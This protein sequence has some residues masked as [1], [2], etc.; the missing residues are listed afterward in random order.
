MWFHACAILRV[1][2]QCRYNNSSERCHSTESGQSWLF[3]PCTINRIRDLLPSQFPLHLSFLK[4]CSVRAIISIILRCCKPP[5][6]F[7]VLDGQEKQWL[8]KRS[9]YVPRCDPAPPAWEVAGTNRSCCWQQG[10]LPGHLQ[11][12]TINFYTLSLTS[13]FVLVAKYSSC[14]SPG[15]NWF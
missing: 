8:F 7:Y 9:I 12:V 2:T 14:W 1:L 13:S 4:F 10:S 5:F 15:I 11:W 6:F 3:H